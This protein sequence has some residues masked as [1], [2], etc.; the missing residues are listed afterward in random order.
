MRT[1]LRGCKLESSPYLASKGNWGGCAKQMNCTEGLRDNWNGTSS[2]QQTCRSGLHWIQRGVHVA[3]GQGNLTF[4]LPHRTALRSCVGNTC[5]ICSVKLLRAMINTL[6]CL[7]PAGLSEEFS[8]YLVLRSGLGN[9]Y[10]VNTWQSSEVCWAPMV[11]AQGL[12]HCFPANHIKSLD[13]TC[14]ILW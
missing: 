5:L 6:C 10:R 7:L 2:V 1:D 12:I 3:L 8:F 4:V 13:G 11:H 14:C 9:W